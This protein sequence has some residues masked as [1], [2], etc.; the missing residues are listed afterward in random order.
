MDDL[1]QG[2]RGQ[3]VGLEIRAAVAGLSAK[4][5]YSVDVLVGYQVV[6]GGTRPLEVSPSSFD[7]TSGSSPAARRVAVVLTPCLQ[8]PDRLESGSGGCRLSVTLVLR[9]ERGELA[10]VSQDVGLVQEGDQA[11]AAAVTIT[12]NYQLEIAGGGAGTGSGT[13]SVAAAGGQPALICQITDGQ[14]AAE[15]CSARYPLHTGLV[16]TAGGGTLASW[17]DDCSATAVGAAC[18]LTMDGHRKAGAQFTVTPTTGELEVQI[19]GLPSGVAA[20]VTVNGPGFNQQVTQSQVLTGLQPGSYTVTAAPVTVPAEGRTYTPDPASQSVAVVVGEPATAQVGYNP[21]SAGTLAVAIT[22]LPQGTAAAVTV[23]GPNGFSQALTAGQTLPGLVPG[24][25]TISASEVPTIDQVYA[26]DPVTQ[27]LTVEA[28]QTTQAR[29]EYQASLASLTVTITGLPPG[30]NA[31]VTVAGPGGYRQALTQTT[32]PPLLKLSPGNYTVSAGSVPA[33]DGQTYQPVITPRQPIAIQAGSNASVTVTYGIAPATQLVF[34][35]Q[36]ATTEIDSIIRP[37]VTVE[38]RDAQNR[39]VPGYAA[40]VTLSLQGD[41]DQDPTGASLGGTTTVVPVNG[42]ATFSDLTVDQAGD[43][44][45]LVASSG[46]LTARS[47][48][49]RVTSGTPFITSVEFPGTVSNGPG[50]VVDARIGFFDAGRD[51]ARLVVT[52]ISDPN[53][54]YTPSTFPVE[55]PDEGSDVV[56]IPLWQCSSRRG[57]PTGAVTVALTLEDSEGNTSAPFQL[58]FEVRGS[59]P[60]INSIDFPEQIP[61]EPGT[62]TTGSVEFHDVDGDIVLLE[63]LV[64]TCEGLDNCTAGSFD[65]RVSGQTEGTVSFTFGCGGPDSCYSGQVTLRF[66]LTDFA[67]NRSAPVDLSFRF[68]DPPIG[69]PPGNAIPGGQ[70]AA[71]APIE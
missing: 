28:N 71:M 1:G 2:P 60:T 57:C 30:T 7:I 8:D 42:V 35:Q 24:S 50:T 10:Q 33:G 46:E 25:Y 13:V 16:L 29:V 41:P 6:G 69:A 44:Y 31:N 63:A 49:F 45:T 19:A 54:V 65:P 53:N 56:V 4:A 58:Q 48:Q 14:A 26:P 68:F 12:P 22:G 17:A 52:E 34:T 32:S 67:G 47:G 5:T 61:A 36:P 55:A 40:P 39:V 64:I 70:S 11:Q 20:Q 37:P 62:T 9:D 18:T 66:T 21:P 51:I 3:P 27:T 15:G 23:S 59:A 38:A 43:G